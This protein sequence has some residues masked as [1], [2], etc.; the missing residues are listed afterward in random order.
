MDVPFTKINLSMFMLYTTI[1]G[2]RFSHITKSTVLDT[3]LTN[4]FLSKLFEFNKYLGAITFNTSLGIAIPWESVRFIYPHASEY[5]IN[6]T[7]KKYNISRRVFEF[8]NFAIHIFPVLYLYTVRK[9][10]IRCSKDIRTVWLSLLIHGLWVK[11]VPKG[12]NLNRV[13]M[14]GNKILTDCEWKKLWILSLFGHMCAYCCINL[15]NRSAL[16]V[17]INN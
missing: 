17:K 10:W 13:Y 15:K 9:H 1:L 6:T 16:L 11:F 2:V 4:L 5:L 3:K 14:F 12:Y 8:I 7:I